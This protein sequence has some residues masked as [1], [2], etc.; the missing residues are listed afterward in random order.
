M[1]N[2]RTTL[3]NHKKGL[4]NTM[5]QLFLTDTEFFYK[6]IYRKTRVYNL[7]EDLSHESSIG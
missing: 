6:Y 5:T 1:L 7:K 3:C 4:K 2:K